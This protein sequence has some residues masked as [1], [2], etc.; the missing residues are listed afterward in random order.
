MGGKL[1]SLWVLCF[2]AL[3]FGGTAPE[4]MLDVDSY[5][6]FSEPQYWN[7]NMYG[8]EHIAKFF[9]DCKANGVSLVYWRSNCQIAAYWSKLNYNLA[10]ALSI[11]S[12]PEDR[13]HGGA[14]AA[15]V[16]VRSSQDG[17]FQIVPTKAGK[18]YT[19]S[20]W[21]SVNKG[22]KAYLSVAD[23]KTGRMLVKSD[24]ITGLDEKFQ[25]VEVSFTA[26]DSAKVGVYGQKFDDI[27]IF[28]VDDVSLR[29]DSGRQLLINGDMEQF[30]ALLP[31]GWKITDKTNFLVL[32]GDILKMDKTLSNKACGGPKGW[33]PMRNGWWVRCQRDRIKALSTYDP[34]KVAVEEAH[35]NGIKIYGWIDPLDEGRRVPPMCAGWGVSRFHEDNP[36]YRLVDKDGNRRWGQLCFGYPAVREYKNATVKELLDYGVDGIYVKTAYQHSL[37]WDNTPH[38]YEQYVFNDIA[39]AEYERRWGKPSYGDYKEYRLKEIQ[40]EYFLQWMTEASALIHQSGKKL[41]Y[42]IAPDDHYQPMQGAWPNYWEKLVDN[43]TIDLLLLE[44]RSN[45]TNK[46]LLGMLERQ[47]G[48][49]QRCRKAGVS[50]GYDFYLNALAEKRISPRKIADK[51]HGF[52]VDEMSALLQEPIDL[53]G[54]YEAMYV[55]AHN[56]WPDIKRVSELST[57]LGDGPKKSYTVKGNDL[58][59]CENIA[60]ERKGAE[61]I[62]EFND[63]NAPANAVID[64]SVSTS[65]TNGMSRGLFN[66]LITLP[67]SKK[68]EAIRIYPG[69][70]ANASL[71]S[72][73]CGISSYLLEGFSS[74]KWVTLADVEN[75]PTVAQTGAVTQ[76]DF[77]Y[78][79]K[80]SPAVTLEAL[81]LRIRKSSDTGYRIDCPDKPCVA[82]ENRVAIL[83]E[84]EILSPLQ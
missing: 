56:Y 31:V 30:D 65:V 43:K 11:R 40:G 63:V 45:T 29:D 14:F 55:D 27:N 79:H 47:F 59:D 51:P 52:F 67:S 50:I 16:G 70:V 19:A 48:F 58:K 53:I 64:G 72:G 20:A 6:H 3:S 7:T 68:V 12:Y 44:P 73:E 62:V 77:V 1:I 10:D 60:S 74:G 49:I 61:A 57:R 75:A 33:G 83:R 25:L 54:V 46:T 26:T 66:V 35:K 36:Q 22:H 76:Y 24:I 17:L 71:P 21:I 80:F 42:S 82:P 39:L 2:T 28:V 34:L 8:P 84:I 5:D 81:R 4:I 41:H 13:Q 9:A 32:C 37:I 69:N 18:T 23:A 78:E 38:Q 15:K